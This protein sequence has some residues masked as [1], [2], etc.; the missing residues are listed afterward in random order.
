MSAAERL[1]ALDTLP[2]AELCARTEAALSALVDVMNQETTLLRAGR[3]RD[4]A[5]L[6]AEKTQ[7]AQDY[8]GYA[9]AVQRQAERL[10]AEAPERVDA[11]RGGHERLATQMSENLRVIASARNLAQDV[12][13]DVA[14]T[15]G[16]QNRTQ[17]YAPPGMA[18]QR[19]AEAARGIAINKAL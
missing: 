16:R 12:L 5:A 2:A 18:A 6:T 15:V 19:P 3:F 11:L 9:R 7:L 1:L 14:E 17:T 4:G 8:V 10:R 13:S